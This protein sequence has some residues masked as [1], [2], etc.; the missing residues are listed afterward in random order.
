MATFEPALQ[1]ERLASMPGD[2]AAVGLPEMP[3][4]QLP[5]LFSTMIEA[6]ETG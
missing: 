2:S 3:T 4:D 5:G 6:A 1:V